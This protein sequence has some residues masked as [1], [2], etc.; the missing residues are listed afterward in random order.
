ML[1]ELKEPKITPPSLLLDGNYL[2]FY[3]SLN[4]GMRKAENIQEER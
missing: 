4:R 2:W 1:P 3:G